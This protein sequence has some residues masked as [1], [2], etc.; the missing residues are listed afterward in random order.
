MSMKSGIVQIIGKTVEAVLTQEREESTPPRHQVFLIF[1]DGSYYELYG[2]DI[3]CCGG[4]SMKGGLMAALDYAR[5][6]PGGRINCYTR[7]PDN[8][9]VQ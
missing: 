4:V 1:T 3:N 8:E 9:S 7:H 6:F 2:E 5:I